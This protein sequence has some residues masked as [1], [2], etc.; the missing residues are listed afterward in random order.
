MIDRT[1]LG[2]TWRS[3]R[4]RV[5]LVVLALGV[6]SAVLPAIYATF[7]RDVRRILE[8]GLVPDVFLEMMRSFGGGDLFSL[9]GSV[10]LGFIHP[11]AVALLGVFAVGSSA[12]AVAGERQRG[13]LEVLLAR[14]LSRRSVYATFLVAILASIAAGV[15]AQLA[16]T[17]VGAGLSGVLDE[18]DV[19]TFPALWLNATL[20]FG[21][22]A[23][24]GLAASVSSDR[25]GPA[26]GATLAFTLVSYVL[27]LLGQLW[28]DAAG[29]QPWSLF[30]Y[31]QPLELLGGRV[32]LG[33]LAL[34]AGVTV[35]AMAYAL[36]VFPRRDL[37]AP[38]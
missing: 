22:I 12:I 1:L 13:T 2:H 3:Q 21:A 28:P 33:S 20:L 15:A 10:A 19:G 37:A 38:S 11:F 23:A 26:V 4:L 16:G 35:A 17:A 25:L 5:V 18:L 31:L 24:I 7:G 8:S 34:L 9:E 29:L 30:H 27:E 6:W 36:V 14:P 32:D